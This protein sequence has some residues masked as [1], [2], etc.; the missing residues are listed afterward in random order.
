V[1]VG[2]RLGRRKR[3]QEKL[4]R[5]FQAKKETH[6]KALRLKSTCLEN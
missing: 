4:G 2:L 5:A 6:A 3:D 1:I